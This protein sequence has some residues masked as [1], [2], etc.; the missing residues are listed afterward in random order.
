[1]SIRGPIA[2]SAGALLGGLAA[3]QG[4][5]EMKRVALER[6]VKKRVL[7]DNSGKKIGETFFAGSTDDTISEVLQTGDL[8]FFNRPCLSMRPCGSAVCVVTKTVSDS[9]F[10]H[11]GIIY[12][13]ND[14]KPM[15]V[16]KTFSSGVRMR[17]W[18]ERLARSTAGE[19]IV[20]PLRCR[21]TPEMMDRVTQVIEE[22]TA[23][24]QQSMVRDV[25]GSFATLALL[26]RRW[27]ESS[28]RNS[29]RSSRRSSRRKVVRGEAGGNVGREEL[30]RGSV[31]NGSAALVCRLLEEM[32]ALPKKGEKGHV[33][34]TKLCPE[35]LLRVELKRGSMLRE[36]IY[37]RTLV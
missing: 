8:V 25:A 3:W 21:R 10:D 16:E 2:R 9:A 12:V 32:N 15:L 28:E 24:A 17:P 14:F 34:C 20:R 4:F 37:V 1:M 19:V 7:M 30:E 6:S 18:D 36:P 11:V 26:A 27:M 23:E 31:E 29:G 33:D 35:D 5:A 22:E 13:R